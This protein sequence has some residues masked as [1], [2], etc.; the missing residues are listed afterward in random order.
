MPTG[1][2]GPLCGT[3]SL[4]FY[5]SSVSCKICDEMGS[6]ALLRVTLTL[7][8]M[9]LGVALYLSGEALSKSQRKRCPWLVGLCSKLFGGQLGSR[10]TTLLKI[11]I[12][13]YQ[14]LMVVVMVSRHPRKGCHL[15]LNPKAKAAAVWIWRSAMES[16]C[17]THPDSI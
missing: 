1:Y 12:G 9:T 15:H 3:C 13:W 7:A 6:T 10:A 8:A 2:E 4:S 5:R 17:R 16:P 14:S 11:T